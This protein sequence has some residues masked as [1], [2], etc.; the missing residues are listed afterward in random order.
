MT[1]EA[2]YM[3]LAAE[4]QAVEHH[5]MVFEE[6]RFSVAQLTDIKEDNKACLHFADHAGS[7]LRTKHLDVRY[8]LFRERIQRGRVKIN[9]LYTSENVADNFLKALARVAFL[10]FCAMLLV[11][12]SS[13][14]FNE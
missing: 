7:H 13:I 12:K 9:Y 11:P 3:A 2:E 4:V 5:R 8:H 10:K 14:K 6:L 1:M